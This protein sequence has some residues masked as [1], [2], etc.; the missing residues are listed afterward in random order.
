MTDR[1][2]RRQ[3]KNFF[4][5]A[6]L[7]RS[8]DVASDRKILHFSSMQRDVHTV[9]EPVTTTGETMGDDDA[10]SLSRGGDPKNEQVMPPTTQGQPL[11]PFNEYEYFAE[12]SCN[13]KPWKK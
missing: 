10:A 6:N 2:I 9:M 7:N 5:P 8:T 13:Y 3:K 12:E 1:A 4:F 11:P